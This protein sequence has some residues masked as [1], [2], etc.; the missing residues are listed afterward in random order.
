MESNSHLI[1]KF[2][3]EMHTSKPIIDIY[4]KK[5]KTIDLLKIQKINDNKIMELFQNFIKNDAVFYTI[6]RMQWKKDKSLKTTKGV[7]KKRT[8][9]NK[10]FR[11]DAPEND[12][13]LDKWTSSKLPKSQKPIDEKYK[14]YLIN[15]PATEL[16]FKDFLIFINMENTKHKIHQ[17][18]TQKQIIMEGMKALSELDEK[19]LYLIDY[20][21]VESASNFKIR[22]LTLSDLMNY[23][24]D[25]LESPQFY[26][27]CIIHSLDKVIEDF[28]KIESMYELEEIKNKELYLY[29][30]EKFLYLLNIETT[31]VFLTT[32]RKVFNAEN[33]LKKNIDIPQYNKIDKR[34]YRTCL[35]TN[36]VVQEVNHK[37][38]MNI[39]FPSVRQIFIELRKSLEEY[40][41]FI[42]NLNQ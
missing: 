31:S 7:S 6:I 21:F 13:V 42:K 22:E 28:T 15:I 18:P 33:I 17:P 1:E 41:I 11:D 3:E 24:I 40:S 23:K 19:T 2:L 12:R 29:R 16:L 32:F 26:I 4:K 8:F 20:T 9:L 39:N 5:S 38:K 25:S 14:K 35:F 10:H 37:L 34:K 30:I 27:D 36:L